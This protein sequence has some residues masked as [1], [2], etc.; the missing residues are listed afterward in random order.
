MLCEVKSDFFRI[1]ENP[2]AHCFEF[3]LS[4]A[5]DR[6]RIKAECVSLIDLNQVVHQSHSC[7][8]I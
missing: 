7:R 6:D 4:R 1:A 5:P 2:A 8:P 3:P